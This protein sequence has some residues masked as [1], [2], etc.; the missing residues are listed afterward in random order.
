MTFLL[1]IINRSILILSLLI[2]LIPTVSAVAIINVTQLTYGTDERSYGNPSWSPDGS[3]IA[4]SAGSSYNYSIWVANIDGSSPVQLTG[5]RGLVDLSPKWSPDGRTIVFHR[6][7]YIEEH[8]EGDFI[9]IMNANGMDQKKLIGA[10][11]NPSVSSDGQ[12]IAFDAGGVKGISV[13]PEQGYGIFVMNIDGTN[14]KRLTENF[15]DEILPSWS[16]DGK[17]M[18]FTKDGIIYTMHVDGSN[19]TSTGQ[20]GYYARWSPDGKYIAFLSDRAG[21]V[22][23]KTKLDRIYV[24]DADGTNVTQLTFG[25]NRWDGIFDWSP[26]GTK[27]IFDSAVPTAPRTIGNIYIMTLDFN[28]TIT[29]TP[30]VTQT[31]TITPTETPALTATQ[32]PEAPGFSLLVALA[33]ISIL[34]L[35]RRI[36]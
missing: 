30:T 27:I 17:K 10:A 31:P 24:M 14:V 9:Y 26:D 3:K 2:F 1:Y 8:H 21:D 23:R 11:R 25:A 32:T 4:Y 20:G 6:I 18:V 16:P 5:G 35:I 22:F 15:G 36:K 34:V 19:M 28:V 13:T 12:Y 29:P 33:S 7:E